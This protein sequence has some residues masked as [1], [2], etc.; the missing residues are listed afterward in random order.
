M[1]KAVTAT[2]ILVL[3]VIALIWMLFPID[4]TPENGQPPPHAIDQSD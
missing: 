3:V 1:S 2:V 4:G